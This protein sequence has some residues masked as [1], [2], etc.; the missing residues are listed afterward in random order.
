V[1]PDLGYF[2]GIVPCGIAEHGVTSLAA[3]GITASMAEVDIALRETFEEV[4]AA[5]LCRT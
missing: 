4:F 5:P 1:D 3:L 2:R